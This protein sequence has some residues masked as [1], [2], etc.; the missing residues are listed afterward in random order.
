[1]K[2]Q[3]TILKLLEIMEKKFNKVSEK[4][5]IFHNLKYKDGTPYIN[6]DE[7]YKKYVNE[8]EYKL[9]LDNNNKPIYNSEIVG[10]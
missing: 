8:D 6:F 4:E 9:I 3:I 10:I 2:E 5:T 7:K 1:M